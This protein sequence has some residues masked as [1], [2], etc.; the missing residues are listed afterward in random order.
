MLAELNKEE[1]AVILMLLD[2]SVEEEAA[3][4][5]LVDFTGEEEVRSIVSDRSEA[6]LLILVDLNVMEGIEPSLSDCRDEGF[7]WERASGCVVVYLFEAEAVVGVFW[8]Y[9]HS[10]PRSLHLPQG[11]F[12]SQFL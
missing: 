9:T 5:I 1:E 10:A 8:G 4:L 11:R 3:S 12:R 7:I 6:V 2:L